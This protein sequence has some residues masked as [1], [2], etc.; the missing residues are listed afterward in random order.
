MEKDVSITEPKLARD[1]GG[2][3][4]EEALRVVQ[5]MPKLEPAKQGDVII[6]TVM[7][8]PVEFKLKEEDSK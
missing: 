3:C 1:I 2:G 7:A 4:G 6:R 5:L 8:L